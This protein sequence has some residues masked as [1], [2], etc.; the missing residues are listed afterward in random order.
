MVVCQP[1]E[2]VEQKIESLNDA[3]VNGEDP[4]IDN[5][6]EV[7]PVLE[8]NSRVVNDVFSK[9]LSESLNKLNLCPSNVSHPIEESDAK[10]QY[11]LKNDRRLNAMESLG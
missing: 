6:K 8:N 4:N 7:L 11:K 5:Q 3:D 2:E 1:P 9:D 10:Q